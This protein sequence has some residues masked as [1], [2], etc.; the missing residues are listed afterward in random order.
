MKTYLEYGHVKGTQR[1]NRKQALARIKELL[2]G[3]EDI[4]NGRKISDISDDD[5][6]EIGFNHFGFEEED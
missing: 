5:L 3:D 4:L 2:R 1:Y 6:I